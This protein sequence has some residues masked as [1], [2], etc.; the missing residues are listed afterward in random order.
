MSS[1]LTSPA[2]LPTSEFWAEIRPLMPLAPLPQV[3]APMLAKVE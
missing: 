3:T 2:L 1:T